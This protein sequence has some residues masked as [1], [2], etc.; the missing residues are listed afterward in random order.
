MIDNTV[1]TPYIRL[2]P[3]LL[4]A[5]A[6]IDSPIEVSMPYI[7]LHPFLQYP[8]KTNDFS[9]CSN[10]KFAH[11]FQPGPFF[12]F[13]RLIFGFFE[14]FPKYILK[15]ISVLY[16]TFHPY[17]RKNFRLLPPSPFSSP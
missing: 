6:E 11:V 3:F 10:P 14:I 17:S 13:F 4:K 5:Y 12:L 16:L 7:G 2:L 9:V 1:S 15:P 8:S